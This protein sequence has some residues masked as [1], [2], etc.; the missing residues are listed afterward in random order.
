[1]KFTLV[2][3]FFGI[4]G[5]IAAI[6][7]EASATRNEKSMEQRIFSFFYSNNSYF[8]FLLQCFH[9]F[10]L[11]HSKTRVVDHKVVAEMVLATLPL[12]VQTKEELQAEIAQ[13]GKRQ[14]RTK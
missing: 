13:L 12:N 5:K 7:K 14:K 8:L 9:Y 11:Y 3:L 4:L 6:E 10:R 2:V 1:M